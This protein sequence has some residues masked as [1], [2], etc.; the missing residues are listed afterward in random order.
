MDA[1]IASHWFPDI[2]ILIIILLFALI[3]GKKGFF[4][5]VIPVVILAAALVGSYF[6]TPYVEPMAQEKLMPFVQ[7]K[8]IE[9]IDSSELGNLGNLSELIEKNAAEKEKKTEK[10]R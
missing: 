8:V 5:C 1:F 3:K 6:I 9:K 4:K 10:E 2:L 7:E